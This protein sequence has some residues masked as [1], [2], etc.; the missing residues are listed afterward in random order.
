MIGD[1]AFASPFPSGADTMAARHKGVA[2]VM[3]RPISVKYLV[4]EH[5]AD[6]NVPDLW[7]YTPLHYTS[8]RGDNE[9]IEYL[10][11]QGEN[12]Q[13]ISRLGQSTADMARGGRAGYFDRTTYPE[14]VKLLQDLGSPM[15]CLHTM[16]RGT[17]DYC[18]V[19]GV[20]PFTTV[21]TEGGAP[22]F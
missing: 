4:E 11:A 2:P 1:K 19:V 21:D 5:G 13:A 8:V 10:V 18:P 7:G 20:D 12:V 6:V 16:F 15:R 17:G 9:V 14:T 3:S 22:S